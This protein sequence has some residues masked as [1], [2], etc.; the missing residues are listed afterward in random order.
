MPQPFHGGALKKSRFILQKGRVF[1][2][3]DFSLDFSS[4]NLKCNSR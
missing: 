2:I 3:I 4:I 1:M